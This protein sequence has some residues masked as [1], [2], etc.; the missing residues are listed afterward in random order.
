MEK[1]MMLWLAGLD[2][3]P[4]ELFEAAKVD[5]AGS[6]QSFFHVALPGLKST[7]FLV[8]VL[9][10]VN[11]FKVFREAYLI[12]GS[13][14]ND[15]IYMLQHLFNNWYGNLDVDKM[16]AGA[17]MMALFVFVLIML[18]QKILNRGDNA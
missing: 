2:G 6:W 17:V 7:A 15:S 11:S 9:S 5:G 3:I 4:K 10:V 18:L 14:P 1:H 16:C 12:A 13:Y 8:L